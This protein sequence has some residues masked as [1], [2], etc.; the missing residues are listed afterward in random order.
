MPIHNDPRRYIFRT[1]DLAPD[2]SRLYWQQYIFSVVTGVFLVTGP[3]LLVFGV[4]KFMQENRPIVALLE[5]TI[6][7]LVMFFALAKQIPLRFR[8]PMLIYALVGMSVLLTITAGPY[9]SGIAF[10]LL[11]CALA[12]LLMSMRE[13]LVLLACNVTI[14]L[15]MTWAVMSSRMTRFPIDQVRD[16]WLIIMASTCVVGSVI[17][18]I[19][20]TTMTGLHQQSAIIQAQVLDIRSVFD[21]IMDAVLVIDANGVIDQHNSQA[22]AWY[23][24]SLQGRSRRSGSAQYKGAAGMIGDVSREGERPHEL[25]GMNISELF[26]LYDPV[27]GAL[28]QSPEGQGLF[29]LVS[30]TLTGP[31][32]SL[33]YQGVILPVGKT[34]ETAGQLDVMPGSRRIGKRHVICTVRRVVSHAEAVLAGGTSRAVLICRDVTEQVQD[35]ASRLHREKMEAVGNLAGGI[36]HDFN[37][38]LMGII[39]FS[40]L[41]EQDLEDLH[42]PFDGPE[43][44][45]GGAIDSD[46]LRDRVKTLQGYV[47]EIQEASKGA[48]KLVKQVQAQSRLAESAIELIDVHVCIRDAV[49]LMA[50]TIDR[51]ITIVHDLKAPDHRVR[52]GAAQLM[53]AVLNL[54][55]N[56]RDAMPAGGRISISTKVVDVADTTQF[57]GFM[58]YPPPL[59]GP[60]ICV[61]VKDTGVGISD[62][63]MARVFEPFFTTKTRGKGTGFGLSSVLNALELS[64][65]FI[66][67][68]SWIGIG[69]EFA[70]YIPLILDGTE[71]LS[72]QADN[73]TSDDLSSR[74][75]VTPDPHEALLSQE[76]HRRINILPGVRVFD[77]GDANRSV[78]SDEVMLRERRKVR[79]GIGRKQ[80]QGVCLI[81]DD[82]KQ[83]R[84]TVSRTLQS[85]GVKVFTAEDGYVA[86]SQYSGHRNEIDLVLLDVNMPNMDGERTLE[87]IKA[88]NQY[89][90]IIV[91]TGFAEEEKLERM[92]RDAAVIGILRKPFTRAQL[93]DAVGL[94]LP[95][96]L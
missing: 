38:T 94:V 29:G 22:E 33:T 68:R 32:D 40:E 51:S 84:E 66:V 37:N 91:I 34:E 75:R 9:R 50:R 45:Y 78:E 39:G 92:R 70:L 61:M 82:E 31:N 23:D 19:V 69:T 67:V 79:Q 77:R 21:S 26:E 10:V 63:L 81:A 1:Q 73:E 62:E 80:L 25:I 14:S 15:V 83:V 8:K 30:A 17:T 2:H 76:V 86:L 41:L 42:A 3:I 56:A 47:H 60:H 12:G 89:V 16:S 4:Y 11:A 48:A 59:F 44:Q 28:Y 55:I 85:W 20:F 24:A 35:Q 65:G 7:L 6:F 54:G 87:K 57:E 96:S 71:L 52:G 46:T 13:I 58:V 93:Y 74:D 18:L 27:S 90:R 36:A 53:N 5:I 64:D 49:R 43:A 95:V 72:L 88:I